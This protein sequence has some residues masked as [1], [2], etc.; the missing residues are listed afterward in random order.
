[1]DVQMPEV[2]GFEATAIIR[3]KEKGGSDRLPIVALTAH[4]LKEDRK[5]CLHAGMDDYISKPLNPEEFFRT[6]ARVVK[7]NRKR[8]FDRPGHSE[9]KEG[10]A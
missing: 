8:L 1:M 2:D 4:A 3:E 7:K 6:I 10:G 9:R 5:R